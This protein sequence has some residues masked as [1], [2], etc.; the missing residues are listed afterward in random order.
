MMHHTATA[1]KTLFVHRIAWLIDSMAGMHMSTAR[2]LCT[3]DHCGQGLYQ[4]IQCYTRERS[5]ADLNF[6]DKLVESMNLLASPTPMSLEAKQV[7]V[8][9]IQC[10]YRAGR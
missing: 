4:S 1:L 10:P 8:A 5:W 7:R 3:S 6:A 2:L 9:L